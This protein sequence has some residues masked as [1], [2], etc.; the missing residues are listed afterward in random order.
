MKEPL[1]ELPP[2]LR[3]SVLPAPTWTVPVLLKVAETVVVP[4]LKLVAKVPALLKTLLPM[5][6]EIEP[7]TLSLKIALTELM[8][9]DP[10]T[11]VP[12]GLVPM[13]IEP[14]VQL[15]VPSFCSLRPPS[16]A[17]MPALS[18]PPACKSVV[19]LPLSTT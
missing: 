12:N 18:V 17:R 1:A 3:L 8:M 5:L 10:P 15:N 19:P 13:E 9:V 14:P 6:V 2:L 7:A 16:R 11:E 4:L